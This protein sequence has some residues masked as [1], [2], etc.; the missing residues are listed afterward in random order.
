MDLRRDNDIHGELRSLLEL[1]CEHRL[2]SEERNRLN[3]ILRED[4]NA[5][6]CYV[7]FMD[8]HGLLHYEAGFAGASSDDIL[9]RV[10]RDDQNARHV[11]DVVPTNACPSARRRVPRLVSGALV[12]ASLAGSVAIL[13]WYLA[14][15]HR[16]RPREDVV[17]INEPGVACIARL[18]RVQWQGDEDGLREWSRLSAGQRLRLASGRV[19]LFFDRGAVLIVE[20]PADLQVVNS[21]RARARQGKI[22]A[23][24]GADASGFAIETP[25]G[26]VIDLGTEFGLQVTQAGTT[27]VVV[28]R[29]KVDFRYQPAERLHEPAQTRRLTS[30]E[31]L[32]VDR[33]G[34][35]SRIM[36]VDSD[37]FPASAD[38]TVR[39]EVSS[40]LIAAIKDNLREP[41]SAK[42][43]QIVRRG[44]SEDARAYVD[45]DHEWNGVDVAGL[46]A[47]LRGADYVRTFN[48]D[49]RAGD[50]KTT[51]TLTR[52]AVLYVLF[53]DRYEPP[54]W[55]R[56]AF[57]D[58]GF[59]VGLDEGPSPLIDLSVGVGPGVSI[60]QVFSVWKR[61]VEKPGCITLGPMG[62]KVGGKAMYGIAATEYPPKPA[63]LPEHTR[64]NLGELSKP[65]R[66]EWL[67]RSGNVHS[68]LYE[69]EPYQ[70]KK[71]RVYALYASPK[72]LGTE[73]AT[74]SGRTYPAV[75]LVH[76]GM[77]HAYPQWVE[78]YARRGY[79]AIAMDLGG[80]I[81]VGQERERL[82][83]G[84]P[85]QDDRL[86]FETPELPD[87]DHWTYHA[88][89]DVILAHSLIRS[90]SEVDPQRTGVVGV[91][92]GGYL[93]CIAA[94]VDDR[95]TAAL[96]M[97]GCGFVYANSHWAYK[98][99]RQQN[100][101]WTAKWARQWDPSAYVGSLTTPIL[102]VT[103]SRDQYYPLDSLA[104]TY[105]LV[106]GLKYMRIEPD[107][108]HGHWFDQPECLA[109]MDQQ[110]QG[111]PPLPRVIRCELRDGRTVV[112]VQGP[113]PIAEATLHY[114]TGRHEESTT[115]RWIALPMRIEGSRT[116]G[117]A[118]PDNTTAWFVTVKDE[119]GLMISSEAVVK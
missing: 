73:T 61:V 45:R 112:D 9:P 91:S 96:S 69:A 25:A 29:G 105:T 15:T 74:E 49:K 57:R 95:Y 107:M 100:P 37:Q 115:R 97:Y 83:D 27:D 114:T 65:P 101:A 44:L 46:P 52:P 93:T 28:F 111:G 108:K 64:W 119:R 31:A 56:E 85:P 72:T 106:N 12:L 47:F 8:L 41:D 103:G 60:D 81:G 2:S 39:P 51:V 30:G 50:L 11:A 4:E 82:D 54:I 68:L 78:L 34:R 89:A 70:G 17:G 48:D 10:F 80:S 94:A 116:V 67:D 16:D 84:G 66:Y 92:W 5:R 110:L 26:E 90:F 77:G 87:C 6:Q 58:T 86:I 18:C 88:V 109:F 23:R 13:A 98:F 99:D 7:R 113:T 71:T 36:A 35:F 59:D 62:K 38:P 14:S 118:P 55:L 40:G 24:V 20:G 75:V 102:F 21:M 3:T 1:H 76:G 22:T 42:Y 117:E 32:R 43:Y 63:P 104:K 53:D 33:Q 79:A 19:E